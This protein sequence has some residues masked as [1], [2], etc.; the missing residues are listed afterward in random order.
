MWMS[1][2]NFTV[3]PSTTV[4]TY[5]TPDYSTLNQSHGNRKWQDIKSVFWNVYSQTSVET[6]P[7]GFH[8]TMELELAKPV[9]L[10]SYLI[11]V[12]DVQ[13]T[14]IWKMFVHV[15]V[16]P[17]RTSEYRGGLSPNGFQELVFCLWVSQPIKQCGLE[18]IMKNNLTSQQ[19]YTAP[20]IWFTR[21]VKIPV[22][23]SPKPQHKWLLLHQTSPLVTII[24]TSLGGKQGLQRSGVHGNKRGTEPWNTTPQKSSWLTV[25]HFN[26]L[27]IHQIP[28]YGK[29]MPWTLMSPSQR[30]PQAAKQPDLQ[31]RRVTGGSK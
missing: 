24:T 15:Y 17:P 6:F 14:S 9:G 20:S 23:C 16:Y 25:D 31:R 30:V 27:L 18:A 13:N 19:L 8:C 3:I 7:A 12:A 11:I 22:C 28:H 21:E 4:M 29:L 2:E 10:I 26:P 1:V 5:F